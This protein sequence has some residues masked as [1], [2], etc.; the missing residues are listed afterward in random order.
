[1]D[2]YSYSYRPAHRQHNPTI[3]ETRNFKYS[4]LF[5]ILIIIA[6][7][8]Y[9]FCGYLYFK[10]NS[11]ENKLNYLMDNNCTRVHNFNIN[12]DT[13]KKPYINKKKETSNLLEYK[14]I[15]INKNKFKEVF[16]NM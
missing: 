11:F 10:V 12:Y 15:Y 5:I 2:E 4:C 16:E 6:L 7:P 14:E 9:A 13:N 3:R 8:F 1:M